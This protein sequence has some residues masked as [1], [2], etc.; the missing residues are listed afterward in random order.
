[1]GE[2]KKDKLSAFLWGMPVWIQGLANG[3][4]TAKL[5]LSSDGVMILFKDEV[6]LGYIILDT[7]LSAF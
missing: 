2:G 7:W 5:Q 1:M 3:K 6:P 4:F